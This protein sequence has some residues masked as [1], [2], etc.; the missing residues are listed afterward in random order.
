MEEVKPITKLI[1]LINKCKEY[2]ISWSELFCRIFYSMLWPVS[3]W[4][5]PALMIFKGDL[6]VKIKFPNTKPPRWL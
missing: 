5:I 2:E 6:E 4:L 3:C 1:N